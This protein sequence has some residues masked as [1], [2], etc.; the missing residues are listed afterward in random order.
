MKRTAIV[1]SLCVTLTGVAF[2]HAQQQRV[3]ATQEERRAVDEA[4]GRGGIPAAAQVFGRYVGTLPG[5]PD[6]LS[7][8]VKDLTARSELI[9]TATA[10]SPVP[11]LSPDLQQL[12]T[13]YQV[14][15]DRVLEGPEGLEPGETI[16]VSLPGGLMVFE[17]G[18]SAELKVEDF[19]PMV[20]DHQYMLFLT[21][22]K[23][24]A[25][26]AVQGRLGTR[27]RYRLTMGSQGLYEVVHDGRAL[28][29]E[30]AGD[31]WTPVAR[32]LRFLPSIDAA[33]YRIDAAVTAL[34][35]KP[36]GTAK[37]QP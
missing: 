32:E 10:L 12:T 7:G 6:F 16:D 1:T 27:G 24:P 28:R 25:P 11:A 26:P 35:R 30:P 34:G 29:L 36:T 15:I 3:P 23:K 2:M 22:D 37:P 20:A 9:V 4:K 19:K 31:E 18:S 33:I 8:D 13:E 17:D 21:R 14:R 5:S